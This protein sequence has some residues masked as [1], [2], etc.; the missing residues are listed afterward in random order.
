MC[1]WESDGVIRGWDHECVELGVWR[2]SGGILKGGSEVGEGDVDH[3]Q[4]I[5]RCWDRFD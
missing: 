5:A 4:H 2:C 3:T 1:Q